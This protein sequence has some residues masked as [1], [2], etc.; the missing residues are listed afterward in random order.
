MERLLAFL[1]ALMC[2]LWMFSGFALV[3]GWI[4]MGGDDHTA[5]IVGFS[6]AA[7][8]LVT[9]AFVYPAVRKLVP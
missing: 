6:G 3:A 1:V 5:N 7:F 8:G 4:Q 2:G 9:A